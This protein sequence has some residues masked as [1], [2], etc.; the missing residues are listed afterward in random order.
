M[1]T[2]DTPPAGDDDDDDY[3]A[4]DIPSVVVAAAQSQRLGGFRRVYIN[5]HKPR[6]KPEAIVYSLYEFAEGIVYQH[7]SEL[8]RATAFAWRNAIKIYLVG[9][10]FTGSGRN[11]VQYEYALQ[12]ADGG[13]LKLSGTFTVASM[14]VRRGRRPPDMEQD[15]YTMLA[16]SQQTVARRLLPMALTA[17]EDGKRVLFD[18]LK[19]S[20]TGLHTPNGVIP[21]S[22]VTSVKVVNG[23]LVVKEAN[24]I[25]PA[26]HVSVGRV[27]NSLLFLALA[28]HLMKKR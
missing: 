18:T 14:A 23:S 7:E 28:G 24:R 8:E 3:D 20:N 11:E 2:Y 26:V 21:W 4:E 19:V 9:M 5:T 17:L 27:P 6:F 13:S 12:T 16:T 1:A 15:M 22:S 25:R 10:E